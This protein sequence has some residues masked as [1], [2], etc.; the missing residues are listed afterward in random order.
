MSQIPGLCVTCRAANSSLRRWLDLES[1][2]LVVFGDGINDLDMFLDADHA[3]A[4]ENAV[5][6]IV[7]VASEVTARNDQDGVV[8]WL[9]AQIR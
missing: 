8:R 3:V 4:V 7:A 5:P 6:E 2:R 1:G 9:A